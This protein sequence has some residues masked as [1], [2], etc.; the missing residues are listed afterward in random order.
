MYM[1]QPSSLHTFIWILL[2]LVVLTGCGAAVANKIPFGDQLAAFV[3]DAPATVKE[4]YAY[5][6]ANPRE[7]E[8]YPC[9]CGCGNMEHTS[10]RSC[11]IKEMTENSITFDDHA[12]GCG[13]CVDITQDVM[14]LKTEGKSSPEIRR[15][16]DAQY[17]QFGPSTNT[18]F[19]TD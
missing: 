2:L 6:V 4:A 9:Y 16:I 14:R 13:I 18:Q 8:K 12:L 7:M 15:Y 17:S 3:K 10:N 5:A 1:K 11:Y 19:P